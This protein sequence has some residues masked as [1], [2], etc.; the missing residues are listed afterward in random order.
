MVD[1][2]KEDHARAIQLAKGLAAIP[3]IVLDPGTPKTNMI[4]CSLSEEIN[5]NANQV[6]S[7]LAATGVLVGVVGLRRFRIV[8]HYWID[9]QGIAKAIEAIKTVLK[10]I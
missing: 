9:D 1:R 4:F 3:G 6:A 2:L 5:Q 7:A 8:L 10:S